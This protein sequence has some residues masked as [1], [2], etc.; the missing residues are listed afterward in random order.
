MSTRF[1]V[2]ALADSFLIFA[3][4]AVPMNRLFFGPAAISDF[5]IVGAAGMYTMIRLVERRKMEDDT[6]R[7]I[8]IGL[9]IIAVG[10]LIGAVFEAPGAFLYKAL[11]VD[12]RDISGWGPNLANLAKFVVGA[13]LPMLMWWLARPG[14]A[15]MRRVLRGRSW[16]AARSA[17]WTGCS[18][19]PPGEAAAP[20]G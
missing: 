7:P 4:F 6:Y 11:A 9:A 10:G 13:F 3:A 18:T 5:A 14:R 2:R 16:P 1:D 15:L 17:G 8:L 19:P 20:T 12:I